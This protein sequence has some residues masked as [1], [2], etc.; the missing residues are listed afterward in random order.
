MAFTPSTLSR[1]L[2]LA[3][4]VKISPALAEPWAEK[5]YNP[6][7]DSDDVIL[8][9]P[10]EGSMVFRRV[11]IPVAGPLDDI[12]ITLGEDGGEW[13]FVEHSYP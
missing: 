8:P 13:G 5:T 3:L 9:M 11:E 4:L 6:K 12:P 1:C 2:A 7:P 10:C